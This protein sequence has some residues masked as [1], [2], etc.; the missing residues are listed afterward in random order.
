MTYQNYE[1]P[2]MQI[3]TAKKDKCKNVFNNSFIFV[4]SLVFI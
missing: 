4:S 3:M 1:Y 2:S